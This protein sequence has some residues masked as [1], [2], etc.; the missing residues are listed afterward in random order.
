MGKT[1]YKK[2]KD[3]N[4]RLQVAEYGAFLCIIGL[5]LWQGS[6]FPIQ[7]LLLIALALLAFILLG[8]TLS[9]PKEALFL[10]G[11]TLLYAISI[12]ILSENHYTGLIELLRTLIFPVALIVFCSYNSQKA[13][14]AIF[15]SLMCVA[16]LGLL[17]F[18]SIIYIPGAVIES[19]NRLQ[20]VIQY[21][22][23][24]ALLMLIGILYSVNSYIKDRAA[25][26]KRGCPWYKKYG[27]LICCLIFAIT[28][29]LTGS[30]T[31][32]VIAL[33]VC[34]LYA[35]IMS[36]KR[37]KIIVA[38]SVM[39]AVFAVLCLNSFTDIR[40]FQISIYE[41]TLVER[42]ITFQDALQMMRGSWLVG[43]GAGNWQQW[44]FMYQSAPY[45]VMFI[46]NYYLQLLLDGGL[47]APLL[48][49]AA[50]L[51]ALIKGIISKSLHAV[52]L[53]A[54]MLQALL[55]FDLIFPAVAVISSFS[56]S[57]LIKPGKQVVAGKFRY[58]AIA[59]LL[60]V[61]VLWCSELYS[62]NAD[63]NLL[64]GNTGA[65]MSRYRTAALLNPL[66]TDLYYQ[67]A[68]STQDIE[69]AEELLR[70]GIEKNPRDLRAIS[71]LVM[72]ESIKGNYTNALD[73]CEILIENR[74]FSTEY[75]ELFLDTAEK[76]LS[77][78][79]INE[80]LFE[81]IQTRLDLISLQLNPLY[82]R[83]ITQQEEH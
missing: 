5:V 45:H 62:S 74:R 44:Q 15:I 10:F 49:L 68:Q 25:T 69:K 48:F 79:V 23:T 75:H 83:Y 56:L 36:G 20:S 51:P 3:V 32:L 70:T 54:V 73:L 16:V 30:R 13:E 17:A 43:I 18:F 71:A 4:N 37:G 55:D 11:I 82:V 60:V 7:L 29:F 59:P 1:A 78:G 63:A 67:M 22:N 50:T 26:S 72:V 24:T 46:H 52:I 40:I 28:L 57:Q 58:I 53:I 34:S 66:N 65:A 81:E 76:A 31:T 2:T 64:R 61:L 38:G 6:F 33:A 19:T 35:F 47:L 39:L 14:Q 42:W 8:K 41:A 77:S 12:P 21:A 80:S 27:K 9:V